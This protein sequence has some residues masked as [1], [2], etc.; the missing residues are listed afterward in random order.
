M[1]LSCVTYECEDYYTGSRSCIAITI[2]M[3]KS[4]F[5]GA[6]LK[7][8]AY[9][10]L[11]KGLHR[12]EESFNHKPDRQATAITLSQLNC[13]LYHWICE[14]Q[15]QHILS[16]HLEPKHDRHGTNKQ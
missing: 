11:L 12:S 2:T 16:N 14:M 13:A 7:T 1:I 9:I 8:H 4:Y 5:N 15:I 3:L 6:D 10:G